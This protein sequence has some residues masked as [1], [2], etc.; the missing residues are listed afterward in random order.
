MTRI[1]L[2]TTT[3]PNSEDDWTGAFIHSLALA[4]RKRGFELEALAPSDGT[5]H[6]RRHLDGIPVCRFGYFWPRSWERLTRGAGG[7]PE[8]IAKSLLARIQII[9]MMAVFIVRTLLAL[10]RNDLIYANWIGAG[11]V[12]AIA[13]WLSGK[14]LVV[15]FRGDDGYLA[16][17]RTMWKIVTKW[18]IAQSSHVTVVSQE[19]QDIMKDLGAAPERLSVPRF[20]VD[21]S[22][23]FPGNRNPTESEPLQ[24]IFVGSLIPKKGLQDLICALASPKFENVRLIAVGDGYFASKL[25]SLA[26]EKLKKGQVIW[27]GIEPPA[28]VAKLMRDADFL[29]LPSYTEGSPNVIKEAMASALPVVGTSVGGIPDL[30]IDGETGLLYNPGD[31]ES[32]RKCIQILAGDRSTRSKMGSSAKMKLD[33]SALNWDSTAKDFESIFLRALEIS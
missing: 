33:N 32:L 20:G 22:L 31:I 24:G 13:S 17:D 14:P 12:G 1:L 8:N 26:Q 3:Y 25:K 18:V 2:L 10:R 27:R 9:P 19:L 4:L 21:T 23:F 6:G 11:F 7:I 16:R 15:S 5:F 29:V 30:V 28:E